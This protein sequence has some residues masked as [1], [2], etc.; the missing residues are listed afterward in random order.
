MDPIVT[1]MLIGGGLSALGSMFGG[2]GIFGKKPQNRQVSPYSQQQRGGMD[3]LVNQGQQN[4]DWAPI[5]QN[6]RTQFQKNTIPSLAER[7]TSMGEGAQSSSGFQGALGSAASDLESQLAALRGQFGL[8]QMQTGLQPQFENIMQ[9]RQPGAI[10][11]GMAGAAPFLP[12]LLMGMG[13][14]NQQQQQG[15]NFNPQEQQ[16]LRKLLSLLQGQGG[17]L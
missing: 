5:E 13:Q 3:W 9:P 12:H 4:A 15:G 10:E 8:Q 14:K 1:P 7:F 6:A 11:S 17:G 16:L 2:G